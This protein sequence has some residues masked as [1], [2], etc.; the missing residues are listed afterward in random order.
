[1]KWIDQKA[2]TVSGQMQM[3]WTPMDLMQRQI[4]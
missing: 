3:E 2:L 1:M 4:R